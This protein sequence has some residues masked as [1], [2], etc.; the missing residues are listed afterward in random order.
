MSTYTEDEYF[1]TSTEAEQELRRALHAQARQIE[2]LRMAVTVLNRQIES[3][4]RVRR[5]AR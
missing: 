5:A 1:E 4:T 3:I 2:S